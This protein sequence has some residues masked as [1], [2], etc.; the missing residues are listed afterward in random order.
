MKRRSNGTGEHGRQKSGKKALFAIPDFYKYAIGYLPKSGSEFYDDAAPTTRRDIWGW[1]AA[2]LVLCLIGFAC[3]ELKA[4][5]FFTHDDNYLAMGPANV[6]RCQTIFSGALPVWNPYQGGGRP[7]VESGGIIAYVPFYI[8]YAI[9][10]YLLGNPFHMVEVAILLN[11]LLA[12]GG[13]FWAGRKWGLS[14]SLACAFGF[15][16]AFSG[17]MIITSRAWMNYSS[18]AAWI[19]WIFGFCSP[20]LLRRASWKW[21][22]G[23]GAAMGYSYHAG[24]SQLWVYA[25]LLESI[26][27]FWLFL[28][29][30]IPFR[31]MVWN[32]PAVLVAVA[33]ALPVAWVQM[34]FGKDVMRNFT[35]SEFDMTGVKWQALL[36]ALIPPPL[37]TMKHPVFSPQDS[38]VWGYANSNGYGIYYYSG[39]VFSWGCLLLLG[40]MTF[41]LWRRR[42]FS[43]NVLIL[44]SV[45]V[46]FLCLGS[47][48]PLPV[49][50]WISSLPWFEKFRQPW[51]YYIFFV[52]FSTLAGALFWERLSRNI[53]R[54]KLTQRGVAIAAIV[55]VGASLAVPIP[56]WWLRPTKEVYPPLSQTIRDTI[57]DSDARFPQRTVSWG[58]QSEYTSWFQSE[59]YAD[60]L[61]AFMPTAYN[62]LSLSR[63]NTLTWYHKFARPIFDKF[64][65]D[66]FGAWRA[67]GVR[68]IVCHPN[69]R[70]VKPELFKTWPAQY[71]KKVGKISLLQLTDSAPLAFVKGNEKEPLPISF[72]ARGATVDFP[73]A[74]AADQQVVVNVLGWPRFQVYA[75]GKPVSWA[76]DEWG[77]ILASVPANTK[78]LEA[79]YEPPWG[80]GIMFGMFLAV[81]C[82]G[83]VF[84]LAW[85]ERKYPPIITQPY[86]PWK[87]RLINAW[88]TNWS[89]VEPKA[90]DTK[91]AEAPESAIEAPA[92]EEPR[93]PRPSAKKAKKKG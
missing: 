29:G 57:K 47:A 93:T 59:D 2:L 34:D 16:F 71:A 50:D 28:C 3:L 46:L 68:W 90:L 56:T 65:E 25:I 51:R 41:M 40:S 89:A 84:V 67:Y 92:D 79:F 48:S 12:A 58:K 15:A 38:A 17:F 72:S 24:F 14:P 55:L 81:F 74:T 18:M 86:S 27:I 64:N 73:A 19:P 1:A 45:F 88:P 37:V 91:A 13:G 63:Y 77:R 80:K 42:M 11:L 20:A 33:I 43:R 85:S 52:F 36:A 31:K 39:A 60:A 70:P 26:I 53:G 4:P 44:F 49:N 82:C 22:L 5:L 78:R 21:V 10:R 83:M 75:D 69:I 6:F 9:S 35:S 30:A 87:S 32:V 62:V 76:P 23:A 54:G 66:P 7:I 8:A 61:V